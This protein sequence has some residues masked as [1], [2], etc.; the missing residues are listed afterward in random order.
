MTAELVLTQTEVSALRQ[1]L[2]EYKEEVPALNKALERVKKYRALSKDK[3][4]EIEDLTLRLTL[5]QSELDQLKLKVQ[6]Q[7]SDLSESAKKFKSEVKAREN[8]YTKLTDAEE[9]LRKETEKLVEKTSELSLKVIEVESL[10]AENKV[11]KRRSALLLAASSLQKLRLSEKD[12]LIKQKDEEIEKKNE[13][14]ALLQAQV[15]ELKLKAEP[16]PH[17]KEW[18]ASEAFRKI[19]SFRAKKECVNMASHLRRK[20]HKS[21]PEVDLNQFRLFPDER[22][23]IDGTT[24][25]KYFTV[26]PHP[27]LSSWPKSDQDKAMLRTIK[28]WKK[29]DAAHRFGNELPLPADRYARFQAELEAYNARQ[30]RIQQCVA[31]G[32]KYNSDEESVP[33]PKPVGYSPAKQPQDKGKQVLEQ[34][35]VN[36]E[37]P[38]DHVLLSVVA[39]KFL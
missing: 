38:E 19:C 28:D 9:S 8:A 37:D 27:F 6:K 21:Y 5:L 13:E 31:A 23:M 3:S 33:L 34:A 1:R 15:S 11:Q 18:V 17:I 7:E 20:L 24:M 26:P 4:A 25:L 12:E 29:Y 39:Q 10:Q 36:A 32:V 30:D 16:L 14:I 35:D 22:I 2:A